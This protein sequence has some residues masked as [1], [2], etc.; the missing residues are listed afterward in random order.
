MVN[1]ENKNSLTELLN[2]YCEHLSKQGKSHRAIITYKNPNNQL[3]QFLAGKGVIEPQEVTEELLKEFQKFLYMERDFMRSSVMFCMQH[4]RMFFDFL[5]QIGKL[6]RNEARGIEIL[7]KQELPPKQ[8]AQYVADSHNKDSLSD[9]L[10][11]Y[12][13]YLSNEG[14][15]RIAILTYQNPSRQLIRFLTEKGVTKPQKVTEELLKEFQKFLYDERDFKRSS[16]MS[17]IKHIAMFFDF[18]IQ[19]GKLKRNE[20]RG[21]E[22]LP[23]PELPEKQLSHFYTYDEILKRYF[24]D[25][26]KLISYFYLNQVEKHLKSFIKYLLANEI[27]SV[28]PVTESTIIKYRQFLWDEFVHARADSLVVK[29]QI[30]RLRC[31]VRLFRYLCKEGILKNNPTKNLGWEKYYKEIVEKAKSLPEKPVPENNLTELDK[32]NMKFLEYE[33]A[34]GKDQSTIKMYKKSVEVFFQYLEEKGVENLAQVNKRLLLEYYTFLCNYVGAR[35][36]PVSNGYKNHMLW[37]MRLFFR[38]LVRFDYLPKDPS[39]DLESI[40]EEKGLPRTCMNEKEVFE[41]LEQPRLNHNPLIARDKAMMEIL[42]STGI[43][44]NELCSLNLEDVDHQQE[45]VRVNSP[46]GG[47]GYQRIIPVGKVALE[48]LDIY[49]RDARPALENGDG[50]ALF[51]SY[52]GH[53]LHNEAVLLMVKKYA[54]ECGFRKNITTHSFRVTCATLMLKNGADI[55]YVQEQLGHKKI[56][57]TQ[58]YTRLTPLDLK[59]IHQRC[60]PRE[61]KALSLN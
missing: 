60:H 7:P 41:L 29:S 45:M 12:G 24:G 13:E 28:Y 17:C 42:F 4:I 15:S 35:G 38:F 14:K 10:D 55:R 46:K 11:V 16:V 3:V 23:K 39:L 6:T 20:A 32:L 31:V 59:S 47:A 54:H 22:I 34:I 27:G 30:N 58:V 18:L 61:K 50:K 40:K 33:L 43:R 26:E 53:R 52:A 56:T 2:A 51:L 1:Y 37:S 48:Y 9:L 5:I 36:N 25:Q 8:L 19:I 57:S 44:S 21:I 49:L